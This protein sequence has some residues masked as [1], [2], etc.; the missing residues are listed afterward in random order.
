MSAEIT[1]QAVEAL[2]KEAVESLC[3]DLSRAAP[4]D[5]SASTPLLG[6]GSGFDSMTVV[7]LIADLEQRLEEIFGKVWILADER[8]LSRSRSPFRTIGSLTSH[9]ID[10][11]D[12]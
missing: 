3:E 4:A 1:P 11:S 6:I 2:I 10:S 7:H 12:E 9:I 5:L 8:A